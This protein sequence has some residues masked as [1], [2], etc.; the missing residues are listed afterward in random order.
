[1]TLL[2]MESKHRIYNIHI[3]CNTTTIKQNSKCEIWNKLRLLEI[4]IKPLLCEYA[5][6][7][8]SININGATSP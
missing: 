5:Q 8:D 7:Y 4:N 1:M 3:K 6:N 2:A